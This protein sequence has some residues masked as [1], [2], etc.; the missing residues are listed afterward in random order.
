LTRLSEIYEKLMLDAGVDLISGRACV[1]SPHEVE[2]AGHCYSAER[3]LIAT[4]GHPVMPD[5]P[6][7][8]HAIHSDQV[9]T[10]PSLP[11]RMVIVGAGYIACEFASIFAGLG[12]EV[13]QVVRRDRLLRAYD[14]EAVSVLSEQMRSKGV[15]FHFSSTLAAIEPASGGGLQVSV[16]DGAR[17]TAGQVLC[18]TGRAP[19]T[20]DLGLAPL[21]VALA[22]NGAVL[23]NDNFQTSLPS[24]YALGDVIDRVALTPV[25]IEEA[26]VF[27][28]RN[29]GHEERDM[30]YRLVPTAVFARPNLATVGLSEAAA[31]AA[32]HEVRIYSTRFRHMLHSLTGRN[33]QVFMKLVVDNPSDRVLGCHM[34]GD[35]AAEIIQGLAVCLRAGAT[36]A[37]FDATIGI[38][39]SAAE[40]FV[41]LRQCQRVVAPDVTG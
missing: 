27:V 41:T 36:K 8:E 26:M 2:V 14:Q 38:H 23:V 7:V 17:L 32:G 24:V 34:V 15:H 18:A 37:D 35:G 39:P 21:G 28:A 16:S 22:E 11:A 30:D 6:G 4:G 13:H 20:G 3:I 9:F 33:E 1:V 10:L 31:L 19:N 25:A 12:V 40:E 5:I 29:F